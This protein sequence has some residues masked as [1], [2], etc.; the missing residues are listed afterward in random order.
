MMQ[1]F[2]PDH[3]HHNHHHDAKQ[4]GEGL[5]S[6]FLEEVAGMDLWADDDDAIKA[7][8]VDSF[9]AMMG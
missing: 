7:G 4:Q 1:W 3:D 8:L 5:A 9:V 6:A 2:D